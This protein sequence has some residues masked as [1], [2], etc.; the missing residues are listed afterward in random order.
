MR[1]LQY[2]KIKLIGFF[3]T[4]HTTLNVLSTTPDGS[5]IIIPFLYGS[6]GDDDDYDD[7]TNQSE[8]ALKSDQRDDDQIFYERKI[9]VLFYF[10]FVVV[11]I[12]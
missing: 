10:R 3:D 11:M 4:L 2:N 6:D 7:H 1:A 9:C 8:R 12:I 5:L